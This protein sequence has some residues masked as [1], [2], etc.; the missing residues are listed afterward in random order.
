MQRIKVANLQSGSI[1]ARPIIDEKG[2]I[3]LNKDVSLTDTYIKALISKGIATIY[4]KESELDDF[5]ADEDLDPK[6]RAQALRVLSKAYEDIEHEVAVLRR[7]SFENVKDALSSDAIK[8]LMGSDG[9][10]GKLS[11]LVM[12]IFDDVLTQ[13]TLSGL[14]TIKSE[15]DRL[16]NHSIDVCVVAIMIGDMIDLPHAR[17]KQLATGCLLHD[18]GKLFV[19]KTA[20]EISQ[21]RQ[22]TL[23]GFELLKSNEEALAP[24]IALEHHEHQDG[25]G[26]P[27][28]LVGSNE[29]E[30][31][32][33]LPPPV[34]TL[35]GEIAAIANVYDNLLSGSESRP[36]MTPDAVVSTISSVA[37]T[38]LNQELVKVFRRIVPLYPMGSE[39]LI[40]GG[41][42][43]NFRAIVSQVYQSRLDKPVVTLLKDSKGNSVS[44]DEVDISKNT[45]IT[46]RAIGIE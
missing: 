31:N 45:E 19:D 7:R 1:V 6:I 39:V 23:L 10:L 29:L 36:P 30:R 11:A 3:L 24:H 25:T 15:D 33:A 32:R 13:S 41:K 21:V 8:A 42:C 17:M 5:T 35:V 12:Q 27:R 14:T 43:H 22:H 2:K 44:P 34:I 37:G 9:P 28:G 4:I 40:R 26:Q 20:D 46:L 16:H 38:H 18:I